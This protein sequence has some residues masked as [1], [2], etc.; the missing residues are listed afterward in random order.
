M[1]SMEPKAGYGWDMGEYDLARTQRPELPG[2]R[3]C[4]IFQQQNDVVLIRS[5]SVSCV[6]ER[7]TGRPLES[8]VS[9]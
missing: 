5:F 6:A 9:F 8:E 7:V 3:A 4:M 1:S 2:G